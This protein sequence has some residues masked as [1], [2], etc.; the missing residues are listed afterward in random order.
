[1]VVEKNGLSNRPAVI[2]KSRSGRPP[3]SYLRKAR[4]S[5]R[6]YLLKLPPCVPLAT[7]RVWFS[8]TGESFSPL[9]PR[10]P[11][12][13]PSPKFASKPVRTRNRTRSR[14]WL[15]FSSGGKVF[16]LVSNG[17]PVLIALKFGNAPVA[18]FPDG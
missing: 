10:T 9:A 14:F 1:M 4:S 2:A 13:N 5:Q 18:S 6:E 15:T 17:G 12:V 11:I 16:P 3:N 7:P 8:V